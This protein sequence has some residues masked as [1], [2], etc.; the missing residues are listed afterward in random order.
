MVSPRKVLA[1]MTFSMTGQPR[2]ERHSVA[3]CYEGMSR[4]ILSAI[5]KVSVFRD[6]LFASLKGRSIVNIY[7]VDW[8]YYKY[9]IRKSI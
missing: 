3:F 5:N 9:I 2:P 6:G 8:N 7:V 1:L 4:Q